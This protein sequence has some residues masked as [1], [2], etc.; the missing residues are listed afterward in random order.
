MRRI[1]KFWLSFVILLVWLAIT[2]LGGL[3]QV[4][5]A[6]NPI[7]ALGGTVA[8]GFV[9]ASL[10]LLAAVLLLRWDGLGFSRPR[11]ARA[12]LVLWLPIAYILLIGAS[13]VAV[14]LPPLSATAI[15]LVN[16]LLVGFSEETMFRSILLR[17][18]LE[19]FRIWPAMLISTAAFGA[20]HMLNSLV[21]GNFPIALAQAVAAFMS[22]IFYMAVR[23]RSQSVYPMMI[24]HAL[25]DF[26]L[27]LVL[28]AAGDFDFQNVEAGWSLLLPLALVGP[29]FGYGLYLLR[30]AGRDY[31]VM[32]EREPAP[33]QGRS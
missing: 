28:H 3:I 14:G 1:G 6:A 33:Q 32:S 25:W 4:R 11:P 27:F 8:F 10:F 2:L 9:L 16:M 21:T 5:P 19:K 18:M 24:I 23:I 15:A 12:L 26:S 20:I 13:A 29:I 17:G 30:H 7:A 22:G 31:A